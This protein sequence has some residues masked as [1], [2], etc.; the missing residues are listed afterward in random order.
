MQIGEELIKSITPNEIFSFYAFGI[1]IPVTDTVITTWIVMLVLIIAAFILTRGLKLI[2]E[3]KQNLVEMFVEFVNNTLKDSMGHYS[4]Y[5]VAYIGTI[6]LFLIFANIISI[7]NFIPSGEELYELT[8]ISFFKDL[9]EFGLRPPT[10]DLNVTLSLALMSV[11]TVTYAGI[12]FKKV[13]GWLRSYIEPMPIVLPI[14]ILENFIRM[15]SLSFRLFGNVLGAF[16]IMEIIYV[17]MPIVLPAGLSI[18]F[19]L[20]DGIL[21]A[22]IF[23]FL[24][25][26]YISE[27]VE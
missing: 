18:Y 13:S 6:F 22:F 10:R 7:F 26:L 4:K 14:K 17:L 2:P 21:Q 19:D 27:A 3:G 9:P 15:L 12:R 11:I 1:R 16:I 8:H 20:F 24:T 25:N 23:I 5:F